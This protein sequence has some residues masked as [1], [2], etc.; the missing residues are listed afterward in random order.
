MIDDS[1]DVGAHRAETILVIPAHPIY[2]EDMFEDHIGEEVPV[3]DECDGTWVP[4][5]LE[6]T[7][8]KGD[9]TVRVVV[10]VPSDWASDRLGDGPDRFS[11]GNGDGP[12]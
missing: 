12:E 3:R 4:G 5:R 6:R 10:A 8:H 11:L 9:G 1:R 7:E 2:D